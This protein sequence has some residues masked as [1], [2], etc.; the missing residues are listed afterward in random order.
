[1][2]WHLAI[3]S[4]LLLAGSA[5]GQTPRRGGDDPI[6]TVGNYFVT[7]TDL[8]LYLARVACQLGKHLDEL[9]EADRKDALVQ[10]LEEVVLLHAA[11][12]AGL[13]RYEPIAG[14]LARAVLAAEIDM[15]LDLQ[16]PGEA[17]LRAFYELHRTRY[18]TPT[19]LR[20][21]MMRWPADVPAE[22]IDELRRWVL[23][24]PARHVG[25][26]IDLGWKSNDEPLVATLAPEQGATIFALPAR[27]LSPTLSDREGG[28]V[29]FWVAERTEARIER[30]D[31]V[32]ERV[33]QDIAER[34]RQEL[35]RR[36][37]DR[38]RP[39]NPQADEQTLL[40]E[41]AIRM[42]LHH[43]SPFREQLISSY[44]DQRKAG[45]ARTLASL[46]GRYLVKLVR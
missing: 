24:N 26:W 41:A 6:A 4:A 31:A 42:R 30:F 14:S 45:R 37:F 38:L 2:V 18:S 19:R 16:P 39:R 21:R 8:D 9:S 20:L 10:L 25:D 28:R 36:L 29:V 11:V 15:K 17:E 32:R 46:R 13:H 34:R 40:V 44:L 1:M 22:E 3:A 35:E 7:R 43:S 27:S 5:G 23:R 12:D 33:A